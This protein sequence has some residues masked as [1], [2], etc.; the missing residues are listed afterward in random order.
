MV[1]AQEAIV[2]SCVG[3]RYQV[4]RDGATLVA[5]I[6]GRMKHAASKRVLV[7]DRVTIHVH[8]D[9]SATI[10]GVEPRHSTLQRRSPG[11]AS[12]V[13]AVAANVDQ[14]VVVGAASRPDWD[15]HLIDRF[16][17]VAEANA[18]Q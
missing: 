8:G 4:F 3:G 10:E 14:V 13:R 15:P 1:T 6:R 17:A 2:L 11:R 5:T 12:G 18:L 16:I 7:G 9:G